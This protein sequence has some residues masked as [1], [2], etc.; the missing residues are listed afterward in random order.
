M[1]TGLSVE[2]GDELA[3]GGEHD[4]VESGGPVGHPCCEGIVGGGGEVA[5]VNPVVIKIEVER[6]WFAFVEGECGCGFGRVGEPMQL[7]KAE[8]AIGVLDV[9]EDA[10]GADRGELLIITDQAYARTPTDGELNRGVEGERVS[11]GGFVDDQQGRG[12]DRGR[13]VRQAVMIK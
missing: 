10:A 5:D 8:G 3:G 12:A 9:A 7:G 6:L 4:C 13:P 2:F 11:Y 1:I